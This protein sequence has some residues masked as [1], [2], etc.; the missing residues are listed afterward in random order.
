MASLPSTPQ[1]SLAPWL[2]RRP[3]RDFIFRAWLDETIVLLFYVGSPGLEPG[4]DMGLKPTAS[5]NSASLPLLDPFVNSL[6]AVADT[7]NH[8]DPRIDRIR[9]ITFA[10]AGRTR[11]LCIW[12]VPPLGFE[13]R[14]CQIKSLRFCQLY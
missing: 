9:N 4:K 2:Y 3:T 8:G 14:I 5:A 12:H 13:P 10:F 6:L 1:E 7:T 11:N